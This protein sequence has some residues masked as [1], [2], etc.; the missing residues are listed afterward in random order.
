VEISKIKLG[1]G[2]IVKCGECPCATPLCFDIRKVLSD[3]AD[4]QFEVSSLPSASDKKRPDLVVIQGCGPTH[5]KQLRQLWDRSVLLGLFCPGTSPDEVLQALHNG[6]DDFIC[7]PF[8]SSD[9]FPRVHRLFP[10]GAPSAALG[11]DREFRRSFRLDSLIGEDDSFVRLIGTLRRV[12]EADTTCV[13]YGETGTGKELIARAI[14]YV[15]PRKGKPFVPINCGAV[16][17]HLFENELF[18]HAKGAFTDAS[19]AEIGLVTVAERGTLFL[20]EVDA[21]SLSAQVKLLRFLQDREYRPLGSSQ[22]IRGNVRIIAATNT[23]LRRRVEERLFR[24]D[25]FH[26][27]NILHLTVPAL[28]DRP[29]DIP[30]LAHHFLNKYAQLH[31]RNVVGFSS[32]ALARLLQFWWPGNVRELEAVVERAVVLSSNRFLQVADIDVPIVDPDSAESSANTFQLAKEQ[33]VRGFER[34]YVANL[35]TTYAGNVSRAARAAGKE[36][37]AFQR[38]MQKHGLARMAF[39]HKSA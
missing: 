33:T 28:R 36:R 27:L 13:I 29:T 34:A 38:L 23:C 1:H 30:I 4:P 17:D 3:C 2:L 35:L 32:S 12:A 8:D 37:R 16:P 11:Q 19:T 14:H 15:S 26:R 6:L 7:C 18:G 22:V 5:V 10:S 20:D 39:L 21:L 25:L 9:F 24:E 31:G